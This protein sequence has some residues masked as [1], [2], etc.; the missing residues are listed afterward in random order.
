MTNSFGCVSDTMVKPFN[1]YAYPIVSAGPDL[2]ILEG[3]S[4]AI[5]A[6]AQGTAMTY[7]WS[8]ATYLNNP[9]RLKPVCTPTDDITYTLTVTG[10]GGCPTTDQVK[11]IVLK[12]P[13]IP[14][15]FSPNNDGI[16]DTWEIEYLRIYP[17]A[18]VQVFTRTGQLVYECKGTYRPW[19]GTLSG[20]ILPMDTYYYIIEPESG[21]EPVTGYITIIR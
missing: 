16:N 17:F 7:S 18:R 19:D 10:I 13:I 15:T 12:T 1:V 5:D 21:R 2:Y 8:P 9:T 11:I 14:N 6:V 20:K 4:Q 3:A